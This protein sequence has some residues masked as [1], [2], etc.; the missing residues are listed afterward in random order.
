MNFRI[1]RSK[2]ELWDS[3]PLQQ[4][5]VVHWIVWLL[6]YFTLA[7]T[8]VSVLYPSTPHS[9]IWSFTK[10]S[11]SILLQWQTLTKKQCQKNLR[12]GKGLFHLTGRFII[13]G[14]WGRKPSRNLNQKPWRK[15]LAGLVTEPC[16]DSLPFSSD[17]GGVIHPACAK[18]SISYLYHFTSSSLPV[19]HPRYPHRVIPISTYNI[20][21]TVKN[22]NFSL[23]PTH[24]SPGPFPF[25]LGNP[26]SSQG[27]SSRSLWTHDSWAFSCRT[28]QT[29]SFPPAGVLTL[30]DLWTLEIVVLPS[31]S[32]SSLVS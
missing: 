1:S 25:L 7:E 32:L 23:S 20:N 11:N 4:M 29:N 16:L 26:D 24:L 19:P 6:C 18:G 8:M 3:H 10:G 17:Y 5:T 31:P 21:F 9:H 12:A 14:S 13:E 30:L 22:W 27:D 2:P 28:A 15:L